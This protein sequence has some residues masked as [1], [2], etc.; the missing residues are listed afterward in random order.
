[1]NTEKAAYWINKFLDNKNL[2]L[3]LFSLLLIL[4][5]VLM[6]FLNIKTPLLGDDLTYS[7]IFNSTDKIT[8][9]K[10]IFDSQYEHYYTWGGRSVVHAIAQLLLTLSPLTMDV[11]NSLAFIFLILLIYKHINHKKPLSISLLAG[12]FLLVWF[13][14]PFAETVLWITG[15]A[16]YLWGTVI[17][18]AFLLPFRLYDNKKSKSL[19]ISAFK[20]IFMFTAG[21]ITGWTNENTVAGLIVI[22]LLFMIYYHKFAKWNIPLWAYTGLAGVLIGYAIM[23][24]APGNAVRA[25]GTETNLFL[26]SY[27]ILRHTQA[28]I[29]M[30]GI[31][32]LILIILLTVLIKDKKE[33]YKT[34]ALKACIYGLGT[35]AGI[36][37]MIFS[38]AF[39]ERA[40]FG[41][42]VFNIITLGILAVNIEYPILRYI[43]YGFVSLGLLSF[44]FNFFDVYKDVTMVAEIAKEREALIL[45]AKKEGKTEVIF[46][47]YQVNTKYAV[48][49]ATYGEPSLTKYYQITIKY[50]K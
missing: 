12:I 31:L 45:E 36:Y 6:L 23:I 24:A 8:S 47:P 11:I 39:P 7:F 28:F 19:F 35:L 27:R 43:K 33:N 41:V 50:K 25:E 38:P 21:I 2:K 1:M 32:N 15:S 37:V 44:A 10:D 30:L 29:N 5:F 14:E 42:I 40:W 22:V 20:V 18:L 49:D 34:I 16:N 13:L 9:L 26:V 3:L 4:I 17:I 48:A 46:E